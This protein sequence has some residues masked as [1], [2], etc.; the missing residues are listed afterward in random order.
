MFQQSS[1]N[2]LTY[3][4]I[5]YHSWLENGPG[6][7]M[8]NFLFKMGILYC[9]YVSLPEGI[10]NKLEIWWVVAPMHI[11]IQLPKSEFLSS[12]AR[13]KDIWTLK[14]ILAR[15]MIHALLYTNICLHLLL[16]TMNNQLN[17]CNIYHIMDTYYGYYRRPR[18]CKI[19]TYIY[20]H[21][22]FAFEWFFDAFKTWWKRSPLQLPTLYLDPAAHVAKLLGCPWKWS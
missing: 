22:C 2:K 1:L 15:W 21:V 7:K 5:H 18:S 19:Y 6:M 14:R 17:L 3:T 13:Q 11:K 10:P 8:D 9:Y 20:I 16:F 4:P 12:L